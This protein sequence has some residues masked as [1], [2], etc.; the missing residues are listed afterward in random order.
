[1]Y[2]EVEFDLF[3]PYVPFEEDIMNI[4]GASKVYLFI[5]DDLESNEVVVANVSFSQAQ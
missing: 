3:H 1:M 4:L 2:L 5:E